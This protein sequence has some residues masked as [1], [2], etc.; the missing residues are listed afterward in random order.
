VFGTPLFLFFGWVSDKIGRKPIILVSAG[1][2]DSGE[3]AYY[4]REA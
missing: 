4:C 2:L 1:M 3:S